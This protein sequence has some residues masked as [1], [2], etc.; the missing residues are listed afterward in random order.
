MSDVQVGMLRIILKNKIIKQ[1]YHAMYTF[2]TYKNLMDFCTFS[3]Q[4]QFIVFDSENDD[5]YY[6][7]LKAESVS[8]CYID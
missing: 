4:L 6:C 1:M 3:Q 7:C 8:I 2:A 5:Y